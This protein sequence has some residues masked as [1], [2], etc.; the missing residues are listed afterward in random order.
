MHTR[1]DLGR[2]NIGMVNNYLERKDGVMKLRDGCRLPLPGYHTGWTNHDD[3][4]QACQAVFVQAPFFKLMHLMK[5]GNYADL[6]LILIKQLI[7]LINDL[8]TSHGFLRLVG[9]RVR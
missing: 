9:R 1:F 8:R 4:L 3:F 5:G 2:D 6:P 7:F